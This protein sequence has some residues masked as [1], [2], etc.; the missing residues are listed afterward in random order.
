M[1]GNFLRSPDRAS[2]NAPQMALERRE[3]G[4]N[5]RLSPSLHSPRRPFRD[6]FGRHRHRHGSPT[7][8]RMAPTNSGGCPI[9][10]YREA[11]RHLRADDFAVQRPSSPPF[12]FR[13]IPLRDL[14]PKARMTKL[15]KA[16]PPSGKAK[17]K[18]S[19]N[20]PSSD[21]R[22]PDGY[23]HRPGA[24]IRG[25]QAG[26]HPLRTSR[27]AYSSR[28]PRHPSGGARR[29]RSGPPSSTSAREPDARWRTPAARPRKPP[30]PWSGS[31]TPAAP[32][33]ATGA[34]TDR[35]ST[36]R[37]GPVTQS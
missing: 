13:R 7:T 32:A 25:A 3:L 19:G 24:D 10:N 20:D 17:Q 35:T 8:G 5:L 21:F 37:S 29:R 15:R 31:R 18:A 34:R 23:L 14:S 2:H 26:R 12:A 6:R 1:H 11:D 36:V 30:N 33:R 16:P 28:I 27:G 22:R 9:G 4:L